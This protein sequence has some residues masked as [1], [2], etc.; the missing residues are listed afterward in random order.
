MPDLCAWIPLKNGLAANIRNWCD[1]ETAAAEIV[2]AAS[3]EPYDLLVLGA[4][5]RKFFGV[6]FLALPRCVQSGTR[7][8]RPDSERA[9]GPKAN[10]GWVFQSL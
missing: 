9:A 1:T 8:V 10:P 3:E 4:P 2:Q 6:W 5:H 7:H